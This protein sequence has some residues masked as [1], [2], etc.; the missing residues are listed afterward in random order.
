MKKNLL[1]LFLIF[2]TKPIYAVPESFADLVEKLSPSVVSIA[3]T[4]IV[5]NNTQ[6]QIPQ[7]P[8]GSPFD[9][10][11][12]DYFDRD[13]RRS[14]RPMTGLGSG[15][16]ISNDGIIVTNNHVIEGADEITVILSDE[17]EYTA[18]LL[19]RDPKADIAVLKIN[20]NIKKLTAVKWGD[21]DSMRVGDW[22]IAIGNPLG[23][24]GTVT[25]GILSAISRDIGG[26]PYV[27]FLQTDASINRGNSGGPLF[28]LEGEVIGINSAIVS[29]TGGSIGL[30]FAI[31]SNSAKKIVQQLKEFGKTKRGWLGIQIQ[32][33]TEDFA[34]SLGLPNQNGAFVSNV[35]P[36]GPSKEAGLEPGD[37]ILKFNEIDI[38]K[39]SDLPRV[40]AE[41]DVG[42]TASLEIWRKNK[43]IN[44][45]VL[46]G[47]LPG[48]VVT[49]RNSK[50]TENTEKNIEVLGIS[51]ANNVNGVEVISIQDENSNLEI[52][53]VISEV[54]RELISDIISFNKLVTKLKK[55]G[56]STLLLKILRND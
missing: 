26:G 47:E 13:Q 42:S 25:A 34:E 19:G 18:E 3:S 21:S 40:V 28:N 38:I 53:D 24:G 10:F 27:K 11:F 8:E 33:V 54:N 1:I 31:P 45:E 17:S 15:F 41:S 36:N 49:E 44:L 29:Q 5:D 39:M 9:E 48:E 37:V 30:G 7:F 4:T 55:T 50:K 16:I 2:F 14:Q 56:R 51:I 52:G 20:P 32:P 35:N 43:K 23:L 46:L 6:N 22:T 12:K